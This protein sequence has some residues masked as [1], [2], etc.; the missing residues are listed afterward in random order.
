MFNL[1]LLLLT[2]HFTHNFSPTK[3]FII[4]DY[5]FILQAKR[6]LTSKFHPVE[7]TVIYFYSKEF[8]LIIGTQIE[9]FWRHIKG[10]GALPEWVCRIFV[11]I[12]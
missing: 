2:L 7:V 11:T 1:I 9:Y 5:I 6:I 12:P 4:S 3:C 8:C 10:G